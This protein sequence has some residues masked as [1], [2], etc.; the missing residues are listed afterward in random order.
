MVRKAEVL[1]PEQIAALEQSTDFGIPWWVIV[2]FMSIFV[3]IGS[4]VFG[5]GL[6]NKGSFEKIWGGCFGGIPLLMSS[7]FVPWSFFVARRAGAGV[8]RDWLFQGL[9]GA[10]R[11]KRLDAPHARHVAGIVAIG[12]ERRVAQFGLEL[13]L[14][15]VG[16]LVRA[17]AAAASAAVRRE[18]EAHR[19]DGKGDQRRRRRCVAR[20]D[21]PLREWRCGTATHSTRPLP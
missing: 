5:V 7:V 8:V 1:T 17:R 12:F 20:L 21:R 14:E 10:R 3:V 11:G 4:F 2:P 16:L 6:E 9:Q 15:L 13:K 19:A 18:A